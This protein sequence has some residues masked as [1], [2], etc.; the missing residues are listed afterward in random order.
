MGILNS[1]GWEGGCTTLKNIS[2]YTLDTPIIYPEECLSQCPA[3]T[4]GIVGSEESQTFDS[5]ILGVSSDFKELDFGKVTA[6]FV[7][8]QVKQRCHRFGCSFLNV[9]TVLLS[10]C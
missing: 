10:N 3:I 8:Q 5:Y 7:L 1:C 4:H 2:L 6:L 9:G